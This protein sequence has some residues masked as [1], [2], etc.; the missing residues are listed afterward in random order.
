MAKKPT[1]EELELRIEELE[2]KDFGRKRAEDTLRESEERH[3]LLLEVSPDPIVLYDIE[4]KTIYVNPA[5]EQTFGWSLDELREKRIDFVPEENWPE[6]KETINRMLQGLKIQLFETRRL[7]KDGRILDIQLSSSLFFNRN[8]K[9]A[10]NIVILR[11]VTALK[12]A[13]ETLRKAHDE[14]EQRVKERTAELVLIN[15]NLKQEI[16]DRRH[17]EALLRESKERFR[18]LTEITSDWIWEVDKNGFYTYVSPKIQDILGYEPKE[19]IGKTPFDLMPPAEGN[20]V[21]KIFN[22]IAASQEPF[23]C[24]ENINLHK[25]GHPVVL[26]TSGIPTFDVDGAFRG[27]RGIDRDI[28]ERKRAEESLRKQTHDLDERVKELNCLYG[29]SK[30]RERPDIPFEEMPQ[31]IVGLIPPSWQYPEITC[32]RIIIEGQEYKTKNFKETVWKQAS[33]IVVHGKRIGILE[34]CYLEEKPESDEGPFLKEERSL[35]SAITERLGR[36]TEHKQA[37][38]ALRK[39]HDELEQRVE[40]RTRELE[41][42][43]N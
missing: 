42:Q 8:E 31:K 37:E 11:D 21:S 16:V 25:N 30:I 17:A 23:D 27:Y 19:I 9:P 5:F 1:Y 22:T 4:G 40:E 43:K 36:V 7:T 15:E 24:L 14:L 28:T 26:E 12:R 3:R 32:A 2:R 18:S 10:G 20:R 6:T 35:I 13:E 38:G 29:I 39:A 41:V 34:I 33:N